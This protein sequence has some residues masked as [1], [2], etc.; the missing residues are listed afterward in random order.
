MEPLLAHIDLDAFF[1]SVELRNNPSL[2][3]KAV[4][5]AGSGPRS[6]VTTASYEARRF[7]VGSAMPASRA[8]RLCPQAVFIE[9]DIRSYRKASREVMDIVRSQVA[10]VEQLGLDEAYLDLT[11]SDHPQAEMRSLATL[12][13]LETGITASIG[14]GPNRLV[15]KMASDVNKPN[16]LTLLDRRGAYRYFRFQSPE[17]I[18]GI[19]PKT[20]ERLMIMGI[21]TIDQL[22][23]SEPGDLASVFGPRRGPE[24]IRL[25]TFDASS[26]VETA[27][28]ALSESRE[29]TFDRD[30]ESVGDMKRELDRL[31]ARLSEDLRSSGLA[32]RTVRIKV[33]LSDWTTV[34]RARTLPMATSA[35]SIISQVA[36]ELL[37]QYAP[38]QPVRLLGVTVAGFP[39][40]RNP[41]QMVLPLP[42]WMLQ[43]A[44]SLD[45]RALRA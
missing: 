17:L 34:T 27:R 36:C 35:R 20:T 22:A 13:A 19:G 6:V 15:A 44:E 40:N 25:A 45:L 8:R 38:G 29:Q 32:G 24:L 30:L 21:K 43:P 7:G 11:Y 1:A 4:V 9:P 5:V 16:G 33:R 42:R 12:I 18:P 2:K 39:G 14:I 23:R 31:A 41:Y 10:R 26:R 3:G 28:L 37:E